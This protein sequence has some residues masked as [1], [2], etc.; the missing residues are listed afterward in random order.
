M[1]NGGVARC[2]CGGML[3]RALTRGFL[4]GSFAGVLFSSRSVLWDRAGR[5]YI[6]QP[7]VYEKIFVIL[8]YFKPALPEPDFWRET[9]TKKKIVG[10]A[11]STV[12]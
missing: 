11:G 12:S 7:A 3:A 1:I 4:T 8:Y 9:F 5:S 6:N 10:V 2:E